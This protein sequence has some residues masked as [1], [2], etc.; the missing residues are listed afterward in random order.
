[1]GNR[2][3]QTLAPS[4][5]DAALPYFIVYN[6][7]NDNALVHD[8]IGDNKINRL[9]FLSEKKRKVRPDHQEILPSVFSRRIFY[10][11]PALSTNGGRP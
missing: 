10:L 6:T 1:M 8:Y 11:M 7:P 5:R 2:V 3:N 9:T 4:L